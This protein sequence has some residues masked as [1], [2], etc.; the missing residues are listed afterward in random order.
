MAAP[1]I[2]S[3]IGETVSVI[4][5]DEGAEALDLLDAID[6]VLDEEPIPDVPVLA[7]FRGTLVGATG[8]IA[9]SSP[10]GTD[11]LIPAGLATRVHAAEPS[12]WAEPKL[13]GDG[14]FTL[15][16]TAR[17]QAYCE[18]N[19]R[20][21]QL[22]SDEALDVAEWILTGVRDTRERDEDVLPTMPLAEVAPGDIVHIGIP[23]H[24]ARIE[25]GHPLTTVAYEAVAGAAPAL[26]ELP[27]GT[28]VDLLGRASL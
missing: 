26:L 6:P 2:P 22:T 9:I 25:V 15:E 21:Q 28:V 17:A 11:W 19:A 24:V 18:A 20:N 14:P 16:Q 12:P 1:P 8:R 5:P 23:A 10:E 4:T 27:S 3:P 7:T 13:Y